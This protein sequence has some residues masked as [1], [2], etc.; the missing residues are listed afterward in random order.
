M[1][2]LNNIIVAI[3]DTISIATKAYVA[4]TN[5]CVAQTT[6]NDVYI[7]LTICFTI[8]AS[9]LMVGH[10]LCQGV[11]SSQE[12]RK[13]ELRINNA[14]ELAKIEKEADIR[15]KESEFDAKQRETK[16]KWDVVDREFK[17]KEKQLEEQTAKKGDKSDCEEMTKANSSNN[18][19]LKS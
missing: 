7:T 6:V 15:G 9:L 12:T 10:Y 19:G 17:I 16:R 18:T 13:E 2:I 4:D 14:H 8:L 5:V 1:G 3:P 11:K